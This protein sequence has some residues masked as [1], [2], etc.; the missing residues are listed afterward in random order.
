MCVWGGCTHECKCLQNSWECQ[1]P[2]SWNCWLLRSTWH[3]QNHKLG[4]VQEQQTSVLNFWA[5]SQAPLLLLKCNETIINHLSFIVIFQEL[6]I[7][8]Y[9]SNFNFCRFIYLFRMY[10]CDHV[11]AMT[12]M[13]WSEDNLKES[14]HSFYYVCSKNW[15]QVVGLVS[16]LS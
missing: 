11:P 9:I 13:W 10:A 5:N 14:V 3:T 16:R 12:C 15:T 1:I 8:I 2:W 6:R 7:L 4:A